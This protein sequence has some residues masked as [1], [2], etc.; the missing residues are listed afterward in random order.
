M[1][2]I[3]IECRNCNKYIEIEKKMSKYRCSNCGWEEDIVV[4]DRKGIDENEHEYEEK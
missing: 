2:V 4:I 3:K 1:K